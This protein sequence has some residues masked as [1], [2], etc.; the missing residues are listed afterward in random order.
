MT[1]EL[2]PPFVAGETYLDREGEYVV[3]SV[4]GERVTFQRTDGRLL[5]DDSR[6]KARIHR[7]MLAELGQHRTLRGR[8][9]RFEGR[10]LVG[11]TLSEVFPLVAATI[12]AN[13]SSRDKFVT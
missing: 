10:R 5:E 9:I 11:F 13:S 2:P 3:I 12:R 6:R 4:A 8:R 7:N 1:H